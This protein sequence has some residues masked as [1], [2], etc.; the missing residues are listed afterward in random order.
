MPTF[1]GILNLNGTI[2]TVLA[3]WFSIPGITHV[4]GIMP[5]TFTLVWTQMSTYVASFFVFV[6]WVGVGKTTIEL[7]EPP[8]PPPLCRW[9]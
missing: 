2:R 6:F 4:K 1:C 7:G 9:I 3:F 8:L 5:S